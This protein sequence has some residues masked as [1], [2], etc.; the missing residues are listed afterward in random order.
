VRTGVSVVVK[1]LEL[2]A[3]HYIPLISEVKERSGAAATIMPFCIHR[4]K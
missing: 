3:S 2:E 1:R 4:A